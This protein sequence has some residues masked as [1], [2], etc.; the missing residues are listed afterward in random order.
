MIHPPFEF[1][2]LGPLELRAQGAP[3]PVN[4]PKQRVVLA[5]L[6]LLRTNRVVTLGEL[7]EV[8]WDGGTPAQPTT[9]LRVYIMRLRR[10]LGRPEIIRT[11]PTGYLLEVPDQ[12]LDLHRFRDLTGRAGRK[13]A[14]GEL[15]RAVRLW[16]EALALWRAEPLLDVPSDALRRS[17]IP[18]LV[19][20]RLR[21]E[22]ERIDAKLRLGEH[23]EVI[24][25]LRTLTSEYP[26]REQFWHQLML[27]LHRANRQAEALS[28]YRTIADALAEKLGVEPGRE[29]QE[30]FHAIL[31]GDPDLTAPAAGAIPIPRRPEPAPAVSQLPHALG[32]L[33][34][35]SAEISQISELLETSGNRAVPVVTVSGPPGVGKTALAVRTAH[36]LRSRF[37][38]GQLYV[39]L[40]GYSAKPALATATVLARLLRAL[41]MPAEKIPVGEEEQ[42]AAYRAVLAGKRVLV[43]LDNAASADQVRPLIPGEPGCAVLIT[44]RRELRPLVALDGAHLVRLDVLDPKASV[45]LLGTLL[46]EQTIRDQ[47]EAAARLAD[48]CGHLPLALRIAGGNLVGRPRPDISAY[49]RSFAGGFLAQALTVENDEDIAVDRAFDLSYAGLEPEARTM[50]RLLSLVPGADFTAEVAATLADFTLADTARTLEQLAGASLL[51]RVPGGRY[52]MHDLLRDY[53][54]RCAEPGDDPDFRARAQARLYGWHLRTADR[55]V[56]TLYRELPLFTRPRPA[57]APGAP[58]S[59]RRADA[60][61]WLDAERANL[62]AMVEHCAENGPAEVAWQLA[63]TL[64]AYL[65]VTGHHVDLVATAAAGL[66]AARRAGDAAAEVAMLLPLIRECQVTGD[67]A[68]AQRY[69]AEAL[70]EAK[71]STS[72]WPMV[73]VLDGSV[74][75][76]LGELDAAHARFRQVIELA[77]TRPRVP[78]VRLNALLGLGYVHVL[79]GEFATVLPLLEPARELAEQTGATIQLVETLLLIGRCQLALGNPGL[80]A[81]YLREASYRAKASGTHYHRTE[82]LGLLAI[83][84]LEAGDSADAAATGERA[85]ASAVRLG[86]PRTTANAWNVLG[87]VR[88]R[89]GEIDEA[90]H[91]HENALEHSTQSAAHHY[92][93]LEA[94]LGLA[95][96]HT[97]AARHEDAFGHASSALTGARD[98]GYRYHEGEANR[99]LLELPPHA[100]P[101]PLR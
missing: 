42:I 89:M 44:S 6:L 50:F 91:A 27:A 28:A 54:A 31:N 1:G 22:R 7:T 82:G 65:S 40:R 77:E 94:L 10:L 39:D 49:N 72:G 52:Q 62:V 33:V 15:E 59:R 80:A 60:L 66:R 17:E 75:L 73:L 11:T 88:R 2:V 30:L 76:D 45:A 70:D 3:V 101:Q 56:R 21:A 47:P 35:R 37:P 98:S 51:K 87:T 85:L 53:A 23:H 69:L 24:S 32:R 48:L 46:G 16:D 41:G 12:A 25:H 43:T 57:A 38:D 78:T 58:T 14:S 4:A 18:Q 26:L 61:R 95:R 92:G 9:A 64:A 90:V 79:R 5:A 68:A 100:V 20:I 71:T 55:A 34:G 19:E 93:M 8:V 86:N 13:A 84:L 63:E 83:A 99:I 67:L 29:L 74:R 97:E 96:A 36:K 81:E